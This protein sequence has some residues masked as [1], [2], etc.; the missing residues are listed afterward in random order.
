MD[1][2]S[3]EVLE[4]PKILARVVEFTSFSAS[5]DLVHRL[6]PTPRLEEAQRRQQE[7]AEAV[8]L[9]EQKSNLTIGGAR[10]VR[11]D[12]SRASRGIV[13]DPQ[14]LL[15]VQ[16]TLQ[17]GA[18]LKRTLGRLGGQFP[19]LGEIADFIEPNEDIVDA[20]GDAINERGEILDSASPRLG[21]IRSEMRVAFDRLMSKLNAIIH[22][23]TNTKWLQEALI[24]QRGGRYVVPLQAQYKGRIKGVVHDQSASGAT[25]FIEPLSTVELNNTY[26]Q[27]QMDEIDEINRILAEL[28]SM[29]G[30]RSAS[31]ARTVEALAQIDFALAKAKYAYAIKGTRPNLVGFRAMPGRGTRRHPGGAIELIEARH[32]LLD[33]QTVVPI[34]L[35]LDD[36]T[37]GLVVTGPNTGGKTVALKTVGLMILM[38]QCGLHLPAKAATLTVFHG[39]Y[40]D[41][42]DEQSIEQSLSTFSSHMTNI[43][44]VLDETDEHTL[45]LLDELGAGTDPTEGSALARALLSHLLDTGT[46]TIVTTHHP[47]L[48]IFAQETPGLRNASV[49]FDLE[50]LAPT[51]RL[52][53]G[54]PGRSNA[55][56]IAARLGLPE[57]VIDEARSLV[58]ADDLEVDN[59]LEEIRVSRD[60]AKA[61]RADAERIRAE[62]DELR[63]ELQKRLDNIEDERRELLQKTRNKGQRELSRLRKKMRQLRQQMRQAALPLDAL[64]EIE[65]QTEDLETRLAE[66]V[67]P[68]TEPVDLED[69]A[70][71]FRLGEIVW[72]RPLKMEGQITELTAED[73]EVQIGRMR[74]RAN[75]D[76][77]ERRGR[78]DRKLA[79]TERRRDPLPARSASPGMELDM[80]GQMV[81]EALPRLDDYLDAAYMAGLPFVRIIHG[82][83]TGALR[84]AIRDRLRDHPLVKS[85]ESGSHKEGGDGVTVVKI[86]EQ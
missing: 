1:I 9:L 18:I 47:E 26:R 83:G 86:V 59:L 50:T 38:A 3:T 53:V 60:E 29:V 23:P 32:P 48:K 74:A 31:I 30:E 16:A 78:L 33:P 85:S 61:A 21:K 46:T 57:S 12:A 34:D 75:L 6:A 15:N 40:A 54:L 43:I 25:L 41:I 36:E 13:L 39:V 14:L 52:I 19:L 45:V 56:D 35:A 80:R 7:T 20:I 72:V 81:E 44:H 55:L 42:G 70:P 2:K 37:Y 24:T 73:A 11:A 82:K 67:A 66:P 10:D 28:S 58:K 5:A 77:L 63:A 4:L 17:R 84:R 69:Q 49:E 65:G 64:N 79:E 62:A 71:A 68:A 51:Y 76:D 27:L 8:E 22:S